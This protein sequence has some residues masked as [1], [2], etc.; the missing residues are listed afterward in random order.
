MCIFQQK[1]RLANK[2]SYLKPSFWFQIY[3]FHNGEDI[4]RGGGPP[5]NKDISR[6]NPSKNTENYELFNKAAPWTDKGQGT[7]LI[8]SH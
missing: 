6:G 2:V 1:K 4:S 8:P 5:R 3:L 7:G